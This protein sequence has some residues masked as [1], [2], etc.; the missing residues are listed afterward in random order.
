MVSPPVRLH[1]VHLRAHAALQVG[2]DI[3]QKQVGRR[4]V[5]GGQFRIEIG[6]DVEVG[7]QGGAVVHIGRINARPEE[8]LPAGNALEAFEID[9]AGGEEIDVFLREIVADDGDDLDRREIA[10]GESNVSAAPPSMRSTFPCGVSTPSYATEPTT[11]R[12]M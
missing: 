4:A 5:R 10:G 7:A 2:L 3:A 12:D 6:E 8:C 11:T 9:L 1:A